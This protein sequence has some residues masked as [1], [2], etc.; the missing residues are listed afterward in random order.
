MKNLRYR[1]LIL[2]STFVLLVVFACNKSF[3]D[4][5]PQGALSS[6]V[7][8]N[9]TGVEGLLIGAY[10]MV[11]GQGGAAGTNW[12]AA[13]SN[14]VYGSVCADDSY[15]GSIPPDQST[16]GIGTLATYTYATNNGY[17]NSKWIAMYDG[18]QRANDVLRVLPLATD[19]P[20]ADAARI[21]AEAKF[22]RGHFHF[23]LKRIFNNI[24][25]A[26]ETTTETKNVD[27]AGQYIDYWPKIEADFQAAIAGLPDVQSTPGA[28]NRGRANKSAAKA[29]LARCYMEQ[30]KYAQAKPL[31]EDI[32]ANGKT[33]SGDAYNLVNYQSNF[34]AQ[35]DNS[36]ESIWAYQAS[37]ND[38]SGTN[39]NYGDNL[40]FPNGG[41]PGGCCGFNNPSINLANAY[42]TDAA[43]LPMLDNFN[44]GTVVSDPTTPYAGNLDPRVDIVMGRPGIPYYDWGLVPAGAWIRSPAD[45]GYFSPKKMVYAKSQIG[46]ASSTETSFWGPTQMSAINVN[47]IRFAEVILWHAECE[48]EIGSLANAL[49]DVNRIRNRAADATGWV[50]AGTATYTSTT[51][52]YSNNVTPAATYKVSPYP[53]GFFIDKATARKA[54]FF[55]ERLELAMEGQRFFALR[56]YNFVTPGIMATT[57]NN[58]IQVEK[59]RPSYFIANSG[60]VFADKYQWFPIPQQQ[61][62]VK[63]AT[64]KVFLKQ[65][66][67]F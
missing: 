44:A 17:L 2:L 48:V 61:I 25:Y 9:N 56:R 40:N 19:I 8:A 4:K 33:A 27:D 26:D 46:S 21:A 45:N 66:P 39:G 65:N 67:G 64:G 58:Y 5:K 57:L 10:H 42:K 23:E 18:V 38:G 12:G 22:L 49:N 35:Q 63:N 14:W 51:G 59:T 50:Y 15:K 55:E 47:L 24:V 43:G 13:A 16:E 60:V 11:G 37:V 1:L 52:K 30:H 36:A 32:I 41:G 53:A 29:Y 62:D 6:S 54:V 34:N 31:L 20:A 28:P 7:L 3:L